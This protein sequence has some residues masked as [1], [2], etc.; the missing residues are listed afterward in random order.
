M[1]L[2]RYNFLRYSFLFLLVVLSC[3]ILFAG[4]AKKE[5]PIIVM[6]KGI[7]KIA[8][9]LNES[10]WQVFRESIFPQ[11]EKENKVKI[12]AYQLEPA[13]FSANL[14][15][16]NKT[17]ESDVDLFALSEAELA[18]L[19]RKDIVSDLSDYESRIPEGVLPNIV[20]SCK[21]DGR[22][23]FMPFKPD[24]Q[25]VYYNQ[26]AFNLYSL[27]QPKTWEDLIK[28]AQKLKESEGRSRILLTA[29]GGDSTALQ[30]YEFIMQADGD[31]YSFDD[32]GCAQTFNFLQ[33]LWQYT[34]EE[35]LKAEWK[36]INDIF[37]RQ[38]AY[39]TQNL[40][41]KFTPLMNNNLQFV[42]GTYSGWGGPAGELH[43]ISGEVFGIPKNSS[44][45]ELALDFIKYIQSKEIQEIL[46]LRLGWPSVRKDAY[47][48]EAVENR[49]RQYYETMQKA[50]EAGVFRKSVGWWPAY[51]KCIV[52]AFQEIVV[53]GAPVES[54]LAKYKQK[55]EEEKLK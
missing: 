19:M 53:N 23:M 34:S 3:A 20:S 7:L 31:P 36:N 30:I 12:K 55:F 4:C 14:E 18:M 22:L 27:S 25:I 5:T 37:S 9:N 15:E 40:S 48:K 39:L 2:S 10:E 16:L 47:K 41:S 45:K 32:I 42:F 6:P 1:I 44:N 17:G 24:V 52:P 11:F 35:S 43:I 33:K 49:V 29:F 46:T 21:I 13:R 51:A 26:D 8:L 38:D 50:M 28:T 54:T